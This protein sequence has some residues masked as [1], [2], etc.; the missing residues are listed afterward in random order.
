M[1]WLR[2]SNNEFDEKKRYQVN[3]KPDTHSHGLNIQGIFE[4]VI[5]SDPTTLGSS[6]VAMVAIGDCN[7]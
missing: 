6:Y 2:S 3:G 4:Y 1:Q 5:T 7:G